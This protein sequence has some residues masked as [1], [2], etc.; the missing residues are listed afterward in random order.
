MDNNVWIEKEIDGYTLRYFNHHSGIWQTHI[1]SNLTQKDFDFMLNHFQ[2]MVNQNDTDF[3]PYYYIFPKHGAKFA[4]IQIQ[5]IK[6]KDFFY[7]LDLNLGSY[8][9]SEMTQSDFDRIF[10]MLKEL[11]LTDKFTRV[12][13]P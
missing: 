3:L 9:L 12:Y 2:I 13:F 11:P 1:I 10:E 7:T 5:L 4:E 6:H 8:R